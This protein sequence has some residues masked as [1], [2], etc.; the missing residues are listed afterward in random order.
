MRSATSVS[1]NLLLL[2][3]SQRAVPEG[4]TDVQSSPHLHED[5]LAQMQRFRGRVYLEDGAIKPWQL[6]D[7]RH[8]LEIDKGSWHLLVL[9][10]GGTVCG[11]AR[12]KE[13][14]LG[15]SY[16]DLAVSRSALA[17]SKEWGP[18][19]KG[20]VDAHLAEARRL[21]CPPSEW[22]GW[23]LDEEVRGTAE[24]L[25]IVLTAYAL[26]EDLGGAIP[27]SYVTRRHGSAS[28]LRRMGGRPLEYRGTQLPVYY[29]PQYECEMEILKFCSWSP[30]PRYSVWI[31]EIKTSLRATQVVTSGVAGTEW[32]DAFRTRAVYQPGSRSAAAAG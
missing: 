15:A 11:C 20:A 8:R 29:D 27:F 4:F 19:L 17:M 16:S 1:R 10:A 21:D 7:G 13:Y 30:N 31:D 3:P 12:Y 32:V 9:D 5:L 28:I 2:S 23:A 18:A 26:M 14:P 6:I 24:A 22:G 25:R